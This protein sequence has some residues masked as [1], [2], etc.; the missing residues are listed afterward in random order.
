MKKI[1]IT[2]SIS[3]VCGLLLGALIFRGGGGGMDHA[4]HDHAA[5]G[6]TPGVGGE[7]KTET[8]TCS[9][10]PQI[11]QPNPGKCPICAMDLIPLSSMGGGD[12]GERSFSM[13]EA[14]KK[15][16]QITTILVSHGNPEAEI[17]LFG[18]VMYDETRMKTVAARFPG[19]IDELF[20]D[21]TG[22]GVKEGD[23]L[24][25]LYSPDLLSVQT[26]LLTAKRF[27][28]ENA[29]QITRDKLRLWG[30]SE[31]R[32]AAIETSGETSDQLTIDAPAS[33]IVTQKNVS[34]GDY[35]QT[36]TPYFKIADLS[37]VWV[38]LDAYESDTSWLRFGQ[39]VEFT[40]ES[41]PGRTFEGRISFISPE[42]DPMTR[43][44]SVRVNVPN[45]ERLLKPGM[46]VSGLVRAKVSA[47]GR[48][49]DPSLA[50]K[51]ISPMHPEIVKD[52]PGKCDICGMD[53][54]PAD[55]LG[56]V[57]T[58]GMEEAP[59][60]IPVGAVL[61][62]GK[63]SIV[64]VELPDKEQPTYEGREILIGPKAGDQYIVEAGLR[65]GERVVAQGGFV[66]DSA[67]QI[68]AKP[69]MMLPGEEGEPLYPNSP[70][71]DEFLTQSDE[72]LKSY[73]DIQTALA[74]DS[75]EDAK[76]AAET[77][78]AG[79]DAMPV[80]TLTPP[81]QAAW[82]EVS[83]RL[84]PSGTAIADADRIEIARGDFQKLSAVADELV[85]RFGTATLPVYE[86]YCPMAFDN[87]GGSWLQPNDDLQNPYFGASMLMCGEVK[88]QIAEAKAIALGAPGDTIVSDL[89]DHYL[90]LQ[91]ALAADSLDSAK[92]STAE[93]VTSSQ[94]LL[95]LADSP[96]GL[97]AT[98]AALV[99]RGELFQKRDDLEAARIVFKQITGELEVLIS[100]FGK[101]IDTPLYEAYCPM[102]LND[103]GATWLQSDKTIANPYFGASMLGC[104]EIREQLTGSMMSAP[105]TMPMESKG[106]APMDEHKGSHPKPSTD[107]K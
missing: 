42:L 57:M 59:L 56:Y 107:S 90:G 53:L 58:E 96:Q 64:Y 3:I 63:R 6:E 85:R 41:M 15:L 22:I 49:L 11:K 26:E 65:E 76:T 75:L 95:D 18:K 25:R 33:G 103:S 81:S 7:A 70:A 14:A 83:G 27:G 67:L 19:R 23:H 34:E 8:W 69:S 13:S 102:A 28:N 36:G 43:T 93:L 61:H 10:H 88:A 9:M 86:H 106:S 78:I 104:G 87:T 73:F 55:E 46:F 89:V 1:I 48:V 74:G 4:G 35:V 16:S 39:S 51:W 44:V 79:A 12:D 82:D 99:S 80:E 5:M 101:A 38:M 29:A 91:N 32:I 30:F 54:V 100:R 40:T 50:G 84:V 52:A 62:T 72:L 68:Q 98:A 92:A 71:P 37:E 66:I 31:E 47:A 94:K 2:A 21:Y 45:E 77:L 20:V 24:A 105:S 17:R 60:L 97:E